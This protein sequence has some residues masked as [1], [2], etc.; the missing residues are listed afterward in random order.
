[1]AGAC[2]AMV[3]LLAGAALDVSQLAANITAALA[4]DRDDKRIA[5]SLKTVRM[6]ERLTA[7]TVAQL[8]QIGA[9][10]QTARALE[11]LRQQSAG[12]PPP[13]LEPLSVMPVPADAGRQQMIDKVG[14]YV[15][16]YLAHFPDFIATKVVRQ[17]HNYRVF[18]TM[19]PFPG[20]SIRSSTV[21][22][23]W[24]PAGAYTTEAGYLAGRAYHK[25]AVATGKKMPPVEVSIGEFGGMLEEIFDRARNATF[26][27]DRWQTVNGIRAAVFHYHVP[28]A[29]S[30]YSVCCATVAQPAGKSRQERVK[31]A[32]DGLIFADPQSGAV[33]RLILIAGEFAGNVNTLA[34]AH[35]L[36]YGDVAVGANHVL[37]PVR[38]IAYV[39][40][41]P[42]ESREEIEY[43]DYHKFASDAAINF[44]QDGAPENQD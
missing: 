38:S 24:H 40:I 42:Y 17:F 4:V 39:R 44:S 14:S 41:G 31:A 26:A 3:P 16:V 34:A 2:A 32:H 21:D 36:D 33:L 23:E 28:L 20:Q 22:G 10:P 13:A 8:V 6:T 19:G 30:R 11:T 9:K 37:L 29:S 1:M 15:S 43:R 12:L 7:E 18:T 5:R 25:Q 35:V 27:W